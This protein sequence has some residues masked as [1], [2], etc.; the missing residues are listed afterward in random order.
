MINPRECGL[1]AVLATAV[2]RSS[3]KTS[4]KGQRKS[5]QGAAKVL[6]ATLRHTW[7]SLFWTMRIRRVGKIFRSRCEGR[8]GGSSGPA[9]GGKAES[10]EARRARKS[11]TKSP[12][13]EGKAAEA[14]CRA[15]AA[16]AALSFASPLRSANASLHTGT[17]GDVYCGGRLWMARRERQCGSR[18]R[19]A[20]GRCRCYSHARAA[21]GRVFGAIAGRGRVAGARGY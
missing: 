8:S 18:A 16:R 6:A 9:E 3:T 21:G 14:V 5:W 11:P 19:G 12:P 4:V 2:I 7:R 15:P 1:A 17:L 20:M 10:G 13:R